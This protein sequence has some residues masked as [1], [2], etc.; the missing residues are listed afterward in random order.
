[1]KKTVAMLLIAASVLS[2]TACSDE[3]N[4]SDK[5]QTKP[6]NTFFI[7]ASDP[8]LLPTAIKLEDIEA[9]ISSVKEEYAEAKEITLSDGTKVSAEAKDPVITKESVK[10]GNATDEQMRAYLSYI[11]N[12][13][14]I[15]CD[16]IVEYFP[17]GNKVVYDENAVLKKYALFLDPMTDGFGSA[18]EAFARVTGSTKIVTDYLYVDNSYIMLYDKD[19]KAPT[20]FF[21]SNDE[22][23]LLIAVTQKLDPGALAGVGTGTAE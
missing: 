8:D 19:E 9:L 23:D 6:E 10:S 21:P 13:R 1:M 18:K 15:V 20:L 11:G 4:D 14:R 22:N 5:S 2:V 16:R 3:K 7:S 17:D 12:I